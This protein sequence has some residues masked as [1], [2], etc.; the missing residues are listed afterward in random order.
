MDAAKWVTAGSVGSRAALLDV[1]AEGVLRV[2]AGPTVGHN[3]RVRTAAARISRHGHLTATRSALLRLHVNYRDVGNGLF[4]QFA[5]FNVHA[6]ARRRRQIQ[7]RT[8]VQ[9][10]QTGPIE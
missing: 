6:V 4:D 3:W 10:C 2:T 9:D 8:P 7:I 1:L 5:P